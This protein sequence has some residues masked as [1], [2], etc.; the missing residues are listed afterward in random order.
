[1]RWQFRTGQIQADVVYIFQPTALNKRRWIFFP[2]PWL[3]LLFPH[4]G[5]KPLC[6]INLKIIRQCAVSDHKRTAASGKGTF[7]V[8]GNH[9][10]NMALLGKCV[11]L[12][13]DRAHITAI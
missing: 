5:H 4:G 8:V 11:K 10:D 6:V 2:F 13:A 1:M 9:Q 3:L 12:L 7:Q